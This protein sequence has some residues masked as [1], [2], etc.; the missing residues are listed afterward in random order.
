ML[1]DVDDEKTL[2]PIITNEIFKQ[3]KSEG[4]IFAGMIPKIENALEATGAGVKKVIIGDALDL[5][6]LVGGNSGTSISS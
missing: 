4:K 1:L 5:I 3:L 6:S 2:M